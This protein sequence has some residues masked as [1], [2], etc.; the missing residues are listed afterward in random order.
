MKE[1][2]LELETIALKQFGDLI[3]EIFLELETNAVK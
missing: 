3:K 1:M 2:F